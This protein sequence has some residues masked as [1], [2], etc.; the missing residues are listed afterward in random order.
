MSNATQSTPTDLELIDKYKTVARAVSSDDVRAARVIHKT[1]TEQGKSLTDQ[2]VTSLA[3]LWLTRQRKQPRNPEMVDFLHELG[4][5]FRQFL[6]GQGTRSSSG[7]HIPFLLLEDADG[8]DILVRAIEIGAVPLDMR[9]SVGDSLLMDALDMGLYDLAQKLYDMGA[10][11]ED[12]NIAGQTALHKFAHKVNFRAVHWLI[13]HGAD[14]DANDLQDARPSQLVPETVGDDW[15]TDALYDALEDYVDD[16]KAGKPFRGNPSYFDMLARELNDDLEANKGNEKACELITKTLA[17][18][19][20]TS[21]S[22]V[23]YD[24][25]DKDEDEY[26]EVDDPTNPRRTP[27]P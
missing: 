19:G 18:L 23:S 2:E 11:V 17:S 8:G 1:F 26:E 14:P 7:N 20:H 10:S 13:D 15:D 6:P 27:G 9:D 5:N 22:V 16:F 25:E 3:L 24:A 21:S 4:F 12:K